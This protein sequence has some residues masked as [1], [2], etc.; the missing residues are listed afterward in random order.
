MF[1]LALNI[2]VSLNTAVR[3]RVEIWTARNNCEREAFT[4]QYIRL[5]NGSQKFTSVNG[6]PSTDRLRSL[7]HTHKATLYCSRI[8]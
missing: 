2:A 5:Q 7:C 3:G 1:V 4:N 6:R 8:R